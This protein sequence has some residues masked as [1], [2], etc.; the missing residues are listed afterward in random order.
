MSK[1]ASFG[2]MHL[3]TAFGVTYLLTGSVSIAGAVTFVEPLVNTVLHY[4]HNKHWDRVEAWARSLLRRRQ[5][6]MA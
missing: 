4:F 5:P 1:T 6:Q 3:G 2:V